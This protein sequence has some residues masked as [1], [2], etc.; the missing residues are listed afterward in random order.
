M[1]PFFLAAAAFP[2][3]A[4]FLAY[5]VGECVCVCVCVCVCER[6]R[7]RERERTMGFKKH[8][9]ISRPKHTLFKRN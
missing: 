8:M 4:S 6:E 7:E 5:M 2:A 9:Y 1:L 3:A